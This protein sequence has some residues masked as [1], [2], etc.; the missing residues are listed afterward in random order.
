MVIKEKLKFFFMDEKVLLR[1]AVILA[2]IMIPITSF[3]LSLSSKEKNYLTLKGEVKSIKKGEITL[4]KL[5]TTLPV[6]FFKAVNVNSSKV[7]IKGRL[8]EYNGKL[9]FVGHSLVSSE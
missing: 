1:I 9:E 8:E 5:K 4:L 7:L 2:I 6:V 3:F